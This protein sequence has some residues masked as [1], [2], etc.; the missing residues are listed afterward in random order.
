[1]IDLATEDFDDLPEPDDHEDCLTFDEAYDC[2]GDKR[3]GRRPDITD[4]P[5]GTFGTL[6]DLLDADDF[7]TPN[8]AQKAQQQV[9]GTAMQGIHKILMSIN[10]IIFDDNNADTSIADLLQQQQAHGWQAVG[11]LNDPDDDFAVTARTWLPGDDVP[12]PT[13]DH[14]VISFGN[15][16]RQQ[17]I[18]FK[19]EQMSKWT[20]ATPSNDDI[21]DQIADALGLPPAKDDR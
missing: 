18:G 8:P 7:N 10:P 5:Q 12:I 4:R 6:A 20:D 3:I 17:S 9:I 21:H 2:W 14:R 1:M 13:T 15:P 11:Y 16:T 19:R